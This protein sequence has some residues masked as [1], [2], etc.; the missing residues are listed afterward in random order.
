MEEEMEEDDN[1]I[2]ERDDSILTFSKHSDSLFC[3]SFSP[4]GDLIVTGGEDDKAFVW[5]TDTGEV[6]F[7]VTEHKDSIISAEFSYDGTFLATGE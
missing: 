1:V 2:P 7:E 4:N 3:G 6:V 5:N